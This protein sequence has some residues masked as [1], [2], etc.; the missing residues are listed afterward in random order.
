[1]NSGGLDSLYDINLNDNRLTAIDFSDCPNL[2]GFECDN[3]AIS[4]LTVKNGKKLI[5]KKKK[6]TYTYNCGRGFKKKFTLV[7][8][9]K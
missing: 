8:N 9:R 4:K 6:V 5:P 2:T 3:N 1:M 7:I